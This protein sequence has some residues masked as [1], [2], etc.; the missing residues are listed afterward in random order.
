MA[1]VS[2]SSC[3]LPAS[4]I[5]R[6]LCTTSQQLLAVVSALITVVFDFP[7]QA[8]HMCFDKDADLFCLNSGTSDPAGE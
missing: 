5:F 4:P 6:H 2:S 3:W 7:H 1:W 8:V